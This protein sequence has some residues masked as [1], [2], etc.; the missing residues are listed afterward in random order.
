MINNGYIVIIDDDEVF[1]KYLKQLLISYFG[2]DDKEILIFTHYDSV[3]LAKIKI[4]LIFLDIDLATSIDGIDVAKV[5]NK[6]PDKPLLFFC[7][8]KTQRMHD[9]FMADPLHFVRKTHLD[10]D[11]KIVNYMLQKARFRHVTNVSF[12]N[13]TVNINNIMYIKS[14]DHYVRMF[15]DDNT[16]KE[17]YYTLNNTLTLLD[18]FDFVKIHRT[19]IVNFR[20]VDDVINKEVIL[21][22]GTALKI[23]KTYVRDIVEYHR[24]WCLRHG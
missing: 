7:S 3:K 8:N 12:N 9:T 18:E 6:R 5:I 13:E 16:V 23:G 17:V 19:C 4:D 24:Y 21:K 10:K 14:N 20:Y 1:L 15:F 22:D 2:F 11:I